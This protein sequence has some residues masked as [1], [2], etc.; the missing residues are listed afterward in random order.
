M[1]KKFI[2]SF[3]KTRPDAE[4]VTPSPA[5]PTTPPAATANKGKAEVKGKGKEP[6]PKAVTKSEPPAPAKTAEELCEIKTG[7]S[8]EE[9]KARLA[10]LYRRYNSATSSLD[11]KLR[12]EAEIMLDAVVVIREKT[13]GPI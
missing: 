2:Q 6:E 3:S 8:K 10:F 11:A 5:K 12:K 1:F 13:F 9:I 7:M 4:P